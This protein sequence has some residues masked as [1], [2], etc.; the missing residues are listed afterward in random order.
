L[1]EQNEGQID[2]LL[3]D[4]IMPRMGGPQLATRLRS[5][6]PEL[7]VLYMSGYTDDTVL[8]H[9]VRLGQLC[10]VQKPVTVQTLTEKVRETL[11]LPLSPPPRF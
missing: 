6:R 10:F 2:L 11:D 3:T 5:V 7:R 8:H 1:F 4:V 9:G